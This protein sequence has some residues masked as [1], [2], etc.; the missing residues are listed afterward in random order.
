[1]KKIVCLTL[2][3]FL[4]LSMNAQRRKVKKKKPTPEELAEN[5]IVREKY[6]SQSFELKKKNFQN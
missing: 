4:S 5:P 6:L 2:I 3:A 1:M